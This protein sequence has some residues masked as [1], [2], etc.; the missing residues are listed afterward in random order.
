MV[1]GDAGRLVGVD[2]TAGCVE[3]QQDEEQEGE[4]P[5]RGASVAEKGQRYPYDRA[6]SY[7]HAHIYD[8]VENQERGYAVSIDTRKHCGLTLGYG[9]DPQ[10]ERKE[11]EQYRSGAN[12]AFFLAD[13]AEYEVSV[14]F[15]HIFELGLSAVQES[16]TCESS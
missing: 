13:G 15:R 3:A 1:G 9:Y 8:Y 4:S 10:D 12:E 2:F 7:H 11:D 14:L 5:Q 6:Q 16:F